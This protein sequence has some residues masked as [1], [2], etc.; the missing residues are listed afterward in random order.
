V[1]FLS[2]PNELASGLLTEDV[3]GRIRERAP[4]YDRDNSF[5][6]DDFREL[7]DLGYLLPRPLSQM[8]ADQRILA[9][10]APAT[11]LGIGMHLTWVGVAQT[12]KNAGDDS[13]QWV[14]DEVHAGEVFAFGVSEAGNDRVLTDSVTTVTETP[15]GFSYRGTKIFTSLS[16]V[17][18]RL[19]VLGRLG[20]DIVHGFITRDQEGWSN[21]PDWN[22]LGMRATQSYTTHLDGVVVS[23][24]RVARVVPVGGH[25]RFTLAI[26][27]N[28]LLLIS[29]I[30]VGI[31]DRAL[32][33]TIERVGQRR[34]L[35]R[36]GASYASD[37]DI[38]WQIADM[39]IARDGL[40]APLHQLADDVDR[41]ANYGSAW[42]ALLSGVK[43]RSVE[44]ARFVVDRALRLSGGRA[45]QADSEISRLQRDV[46][47]GVYHP[48]DTEAIHH[49]VAAF[50]LGD[51]NEEVQ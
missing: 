2:H 40:D 44:T 51:P 43:H 27:Q 18:T 32:E 4:G 19:S 17:W 3:L 10:H 9:R 34:S 8:V 31:S 47:A 6:H 20:D 37:P 26:F 39:G 22:T 38:R 16:P 35:A 28:F 46:L 41:G 42:P 1:E 36:G 12:L 11:A 49:T 25:D 33:L 23:P 14:L 7:A 50:L 15:D 45:Y 5:F 13:L 30:Y 21:T 29:A 24:E 48:S